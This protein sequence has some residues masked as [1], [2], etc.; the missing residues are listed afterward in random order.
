VA[1]LDVKNWHGLAAAAMAPD[2]GDAAEAIPKPKQLLQAR[3]NDR[4]GVHYFAN[5]Y[6]TSKQTHHSYI[7]RLQRLLLSRGKAEDV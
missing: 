5:G 3:P 6:Y 7:A 2:P 4:L 1:V